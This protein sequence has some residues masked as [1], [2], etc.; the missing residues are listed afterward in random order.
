M[1]P[2]GTQKAAAL[3]RV[4]FP[5][6][7]LQGWDFTPRKANSSTATP[8]ASQL[9]A[10]GC[11]LVLTPGVAKAWD[12][13]VSQQRALGSL[14]EQRGL[15]RSCCGAVRSHRKRGWGCAA[16]RLCL[17]E[18]SVMGSKQQ[19]FERKGRRGKKLLQGFQGG[20]SWEHSL[21]LCFA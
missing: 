21:E 13:M 8:A 9:L 4:E 16:G 12:Y 15:R 20:M 3:V 7:L 14:V 11:E 2:R 1:R 19:S 18:W 5:C 10:L 6:W 17:S